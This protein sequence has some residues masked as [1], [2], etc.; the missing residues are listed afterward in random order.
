[1]KLDLHQAFKHRINVLE[2]RIE[3]LKETLLTLKIGP[4]IEFAISEAWDESRIN[5]RKKGLKVG[6][7]KLAFLEGI[8]G[9][10]VC[11]F[12]IPSIT[13]KAKMTLIDK[14][15]EYRSSENR[16]ESGKD[17]R[18]ASSKITSSADA[19]KG[20][21]LYVGSIKNGIATRVRQHLGFGH[22]HTYALQL[23]HWL[24]ANTVLKFY[25]INLSNSEIT[26][27]VEAAISAQLIPLLGKQEQ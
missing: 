10:I 16:D 6:H 21:I 9:P 11:F 3:S 27:D 26:H 1:M 14:F 19:H 8:S 4:G 17:L 2:G 18:R 12:E 7:D 22:K 24:P 5:T 23:R 20:D 25:Y 13:E 15:K